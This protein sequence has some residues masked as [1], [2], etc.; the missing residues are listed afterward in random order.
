MHKISDIE[1]CVLKR[2]R[3]HMTQDD[4]AKELDMSRL[5][6][7]RMEQGI[8]PAERLIAYWRKG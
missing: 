3:C 1:E 8:E 6:V 7:N 5:W 4:V 2:R